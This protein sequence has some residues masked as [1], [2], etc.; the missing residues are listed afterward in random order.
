[1]LCAV[2]TVLQMSAFTAYPVG[3]LQYCFPYG[4]TV[5]QTMFP[6]VHVYKPVDENIT[7]AEIPESVTIDGRSFSVEEIRNSA[8]ANCANLVTL[9]M[10]S[11]MKKIGNNAFNGCVV[12]ESVEMPNSV[13]AIGTNAFAD[14]EHCRR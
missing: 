4:E 3:D 2:F 5:Q 11:T 10:P 8:F 1:M 14:A 7:N 6:Y 13:T 12:L 9:T